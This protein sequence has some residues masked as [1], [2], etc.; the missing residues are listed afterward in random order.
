MQEYF[1]KSLKVIRILKIKNKR[2]YNKLKTELLILNI[3][4]LKY[5]TN[6]RNFREIVKLAE[7]VV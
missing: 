2:Q 1:I 7:E 3:E 5:I 6:K 4:S